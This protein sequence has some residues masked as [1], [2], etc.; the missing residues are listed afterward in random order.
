MRILSCAAIAVCFASPSFAKT[1]ELA[2]SA[3]FGFVGE[4]PG[5]YDGEI[6]NCNH[7][8]GGE[9]LYYAGPYNRIGT[10]SGSF[11]ADDRRSNYEFDLDGINIQSVSLRFAAR[12]YETAATSL[13]CVRAYNG[14]GA[15]DLGDYMPAD[16]QNLLTFETVFDF[17][18]GMALLIGDFDITSFAKAFLLD[19][20]RHL[21]LQFASDDYVDGVIGLFDVRLVIETVPEPATLALFG[22]GLLGISA[23]RRKR[24]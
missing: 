15:P 13:G 10:M 17:D 22:L 3:S 6:P 5:D 7:N 21:G 16:I 23:R 9:L 2:P 20:G 14:N 12:T 24:L 4:I 11:S 19:G 1:I 8:W 18:A